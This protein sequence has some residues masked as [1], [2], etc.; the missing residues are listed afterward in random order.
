MTEGQRPDDSDYVRIRDPANPSTQ[1]EIPLNVLS[2]ASVTSLQPRPYLDES[3]V[4]KSQN[5]S[6]RASK[7]DCDF[8]DPEGV[9]ELERKVSRDERPDEDEDEDVQPDPRRVSIASSDSGTVV[10]SLSIHDPS[11]FDLE[12]TIRDILKR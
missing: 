9:Q 6:H 1:E 7:V 2:S 3:D 8:F 12:K 10:G 5:I 11:S 4:Y